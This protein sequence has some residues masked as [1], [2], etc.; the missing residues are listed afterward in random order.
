MIGS[1]MKMTTFP[2]ITNPLLSLRFAK[3]SGLFRCLA[4]AAL[5]LSTSAV[6]PAEILVKPGDK[7]AFLGD[8]ITQQ[9]WKNHNGYVHLVMAGLAANGIQAEAIPAGISGNKSNQMLARLQPDV[10]TKN[11]QWMTLSCGVNDVWHSQ[12]GDGIPLDG[13]QASDKDPKISGKP[14]VGTYEKNITAII[15]QALAANARPVILTAT[16]IQE[17]LDNPLNTKLE[18][19]NNFLRKLARDRNLPIA[20]LNEIFQKRLKKENKP[21]QKLLTV[22]GVHMNPEGNKLMA[23][24]ILAAFGLDDGEL[25]KAE[26]AWSK[27]APPPAAAAP[28]PPVSASKPAPVPAPAPENPPASM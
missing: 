2:K 17:T 10:L 20:D 15:D 13:R 26:E 1:C 21:A 18:A 3:D 5:L 22:D 4:I 25:K 24:G 11:P 16:V 12:R 14:G 28:V 27:L 9:G 7:I 8:S 6:L 19:Y 23:L